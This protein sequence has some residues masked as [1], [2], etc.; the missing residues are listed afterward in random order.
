VFGTEDVA[1]G[2][3]GCTWQ[4]RLHLQAGRPWLVWHVGSISP[5]IVYLSIKIATQL[6]LLV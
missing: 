1:Q 3:C 2:K 4:G 6:A 5:L